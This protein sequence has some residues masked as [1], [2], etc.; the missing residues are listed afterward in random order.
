MS[1]VDE[2]GDCSSD[3]TCTENGPMGLV[4]KQIDGIKF[5]DTTLLEE[6][7]SALQQFALG[8]D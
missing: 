7:Y 8:I 4:K 3:G 2:V 1:D 6:S 5:A